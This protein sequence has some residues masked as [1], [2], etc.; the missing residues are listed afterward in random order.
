MGLAAVFRLAAAVFAVTMLGGT[1]S[2]AGD[3]EMVYKC[4][5]GRPHYC[6]KYGQGLCRKTNS[7]PNKDQACEDWTEACVECQTAIGNCFERSAEPVLQ[8][9]AECTACQA[10]M[11]S[12]MEAADKQYWPNR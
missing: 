7:L 11:H 9:S 1:A 8:G 4:E 5:R 3:D 12:C 10:E 6:L 2:R